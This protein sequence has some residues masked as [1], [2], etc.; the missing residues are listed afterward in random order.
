MS[1]V[2]EGRIEICYTTQHPEP[3]YSKILEY[4]HEF[5]ISF[6]PLEIQDLLYLTILH[7]VDLTCF[8]INY[9]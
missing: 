7:K 9:F 4:I 5:Y 8:S 6:S 3:L 2:L 1:F